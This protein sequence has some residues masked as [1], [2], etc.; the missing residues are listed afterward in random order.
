MQLILNLEGVAFLPVTLIL[1]RLIALRVAVLH[2]LIVSAL[3]GFAADLISLLAAPLL[4]RASPSASRLSLSP[5]L[6]HHAALLSSKP[7]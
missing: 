4:F 5:K 1:V 2:L 7:A 3:L 6:L